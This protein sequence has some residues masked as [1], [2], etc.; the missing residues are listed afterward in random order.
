MSTMHVSASAPNLTR[1]PLLQGGSAL[2]GMDYE[3]TLQII[4][5]HQRLES[6]KPTLSVQREEQERHFQR[7][8]RFVQ[9]RQRYR[10]AFQV[11]QGSDSRGSHSR[12]HFERRLE[13]MLLKDSCRAWILLGDTSSHASCGR[14]EPSQA[15]RQ[16]TRA[17]PREVQRQE[18]EEERKRCQSQANATS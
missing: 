14:S 5:H 9:I 1:K 6:V 10:G 15:C 4:R 13:R 18:E 7:H 8:C 16:R 11:P 3:A 12:R 17:V 2:M